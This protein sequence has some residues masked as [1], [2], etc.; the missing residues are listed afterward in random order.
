MMRRLAD[1]LAILFVLSLITVCARTFTRDERLSD[2]PLSLV[3]IHSRSPHWHALERRW[4]ATHPECVA[5]GT[6]AD[7]N[8]HHIAPFH[9]CPERELDTTNL[10]TLCRA[11]HLS[12]GH[13][14][15]WRSVNPNVIA[16]AEAFRAAL[17]P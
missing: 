17:A 5:C 15:D 2:E 11:H 16:D 9:L 3:A 1:A 6:R 7:L 4:L 10:I 12:L 8:V 14:G 13:H